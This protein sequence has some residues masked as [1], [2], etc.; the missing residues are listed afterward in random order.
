MF[1][2]IRDT[3]L[4]LLTVVAVVLSIGYFNAKENEKAKKQQATSTLEALRIKLSALEDNTKDREKAKGEHETKLDSL[5]KEAA[6]LEVQITQIQKICD[7]SQAQLSTVESDIYSSQRKIKILL[8]EKQDL[9]EKISQ[10]QTE[11]IELERRLDAL[12]Q[13]TDALERHKN[14]LMRIS[15]IK[16]KSPE[17][18]APSAEAPAAAEPIIV[19]TPPPMPE[20]TKK[21]LN[22]EVL[23]ANREFNFVVVSIG[24]QT[25]IKEGDRLY[26]YDGERCLGEI[27]VE[28]VRENISAASGGKELDAYRIKA[29]NKVYSEKLE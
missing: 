22:G 12:L 24:K 11:I 21:Y 29:G 16:A 27:Y 3:L 23:V 15:G 1:K 28:T 18:Q 8:Q 4:V 17:Q 20:E 10:A 14:K 5:V 25:G 9:T 2:H 26:V 6:A 13:V 19:P 7:E